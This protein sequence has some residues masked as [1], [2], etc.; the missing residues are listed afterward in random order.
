MQGVYTIK[1]FQFYS[2]IM[3]PIISILYFFN[4]LYVQ[5]GPKILSKLRSSRNFHKF[6]IFKTYS[7][8]ILEPSL[9]YKFHSILIAH[10]K[11]III[12]FRTEIVCYAFIHP[13]WNPVPNSG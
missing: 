11:N 9:V 7:E 12:S 10:V 1:I 3:I 5:L 6:P 4:D 8:Q 13:W 2:W